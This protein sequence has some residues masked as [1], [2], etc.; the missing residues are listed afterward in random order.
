MTLDEI[1]CWLLFISAAFCLAAIGVLIYACALLLDVQ[2]RIRA[3]EWREP[4]HTNGHKI[5]ERADK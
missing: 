2:H 5:R 1:A 3:F 4:T